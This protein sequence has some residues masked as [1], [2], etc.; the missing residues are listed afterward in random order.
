MECPSIKKIA[1]ICKKSPK[2]KKCKALKRK[3]MS[4]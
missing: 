4:E 2:S 3:C 1:R